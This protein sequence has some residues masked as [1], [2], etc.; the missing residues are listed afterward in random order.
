MSA[1]DNR[2]RRGDEYD[3]AIETLAY[4][5]KGVGRLAG[6]AGKRGMTVFVPRAAPG[7]RLRVRLE[8]V[9]RRH[10][11]ASVLR[12]DAPGP[13]RVEP[14]CRHYDEGCGGCSWQHLAY[15]EQLRTKEA[16]VRDS[17]ERIGEFRDLEIAPIV[18]AAEPWFYRNKM[19]FTFNARDGLGLHRSGDWRRVVEI[20]EC[21][22]ESELAMQVLEYAREF[23][24][25]HNFSSWDPESKT[26]FLREIVIRHGRGSG[27]TMVA[28]V[29]SP[30]SFPRAAE[31]A[32]GVRDLDTSVVSVLRAVRDARSSDIVEID[33]LSGN[34]VI[35]E[36]VGGLDFNVGLRTFFQTSTTQA[37][38]ML[39]IVRAEVGAG[40][41]R[42]GVGAAGQVLDVFC[43]VGFFTLGLADLVAEAV[44]VEIVEASIVAARENA[45]TNSIENC[46]FYA[47][48]AR[49]TLPE[50]L[51]RHGTPG[52]IVIDPP[53][54]G[55]GGKVMRRLARTQAPR[56]VYVSCNPTTLARD[57]QEMEP[58]G[59]R[60]QSVQPI[61]LFPQTY[62]VE[63][64][65]TMDRVAEPTADLRRHR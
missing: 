19:E 3:V 15:E 31:F 11:E 36:R 64:I 52:V 18:A 29:T 55:A 27:Q 14:V 4:G 8:Q 37:E 28:L 61:D 65:V 10:A 13:G 50:I 6:E 57:L 59:Y 45:R 47:G 26:G 46:A 40:L 39:E 1:N 20:S 42:V 5:G 35:V 24:S 53:R 56:L 51:E 23:A 21:R 22:L 33:V 30:G 12:I 43:G 54:S 58:F 9:R 17:L 34:A 25:R 2:P 41:E 63:T 7:D 16:I 60:I 48:D 62:H 32:A 44:G 49:R 38:R